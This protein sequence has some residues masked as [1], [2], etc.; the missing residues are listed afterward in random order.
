MSP[1]QFPR[2]R[3]I[4]YTCEVSWIEGKLEAEKDEAELE[5]SYSA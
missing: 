2:A 3:Q 5:G 1:T 4:T